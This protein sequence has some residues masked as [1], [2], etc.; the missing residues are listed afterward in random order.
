MAYQ[1]KKEILLDAPR[2]LVWKTYRDYLPELA[3]VMPTVDS[4]TVV[5]RNE[6]VDRVKKDWM[7]NKGRAVI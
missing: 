5:D 7:S 2:S 4:I 1:L 3:V 6:K